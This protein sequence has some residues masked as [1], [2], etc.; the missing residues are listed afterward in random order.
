MERPTAT[1]QCIRIFKINISTLSVDGETQRVF[2]YKK[3]ITTK[4]WLVVTF[5]RWRSK[6]II[7]S[8]NQRTYS[9]SNDNVKLVDSICK[10]E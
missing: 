2:E 6:A 10:K 4:K 5:R 1:W 3:K 8:A 9:D 7:H